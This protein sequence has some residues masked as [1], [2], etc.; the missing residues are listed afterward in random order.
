MNIP[1][2]LN[3]NQ[4]VVLSKFGSH[5][6]GCD[7]EQSDEDYKG[8]YLPNRRQLLLNKIPK[9]YSLPKTSGMDMQLW[10]I[11]HWFKLAM[12][13][14]AEAMDLLH[15]PKN[16]VI[17]KIIPIWGILQ[18]NRKKL[19]SKKMNGYLGYARKQAS[20]FGI[21][22][23]RIKALEDVIDCLSN[24][25]PEW[26]LKTI[27]NELPEGDHIHKI[28]GHEQIASMYEVCGRKVH[29]TVTVEYAYYVFKRILDQYGKRSMLARDNYGVDWKAMS[30]ACRIATQL[31]EM[32]IEK[33]MKFP[34]WNSKDLTEIKE[35]KWS[36]EQANAYMEY[37]IKDAEDQLE[38]SDLPNEINKEYFEDLLMRILQEY[39]I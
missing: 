35:G 23:T 14:E 34:L 28:Y 17:F 27:W 26:K 32:A 31:S 1:E 38:I 33:D 6:Y 16:M 25:D 37:L 7:T 2:G 20:K 12:N 8:I 19:Y 13:G 29:D 30:H 24:N 36:Y 18:A 11:H 39:V 4:I 9:S 21:R 15:A 22:G 3:L 5:L 10:S